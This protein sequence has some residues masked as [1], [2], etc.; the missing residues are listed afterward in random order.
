[1]HDWTATAIGTVG[2][3]LLL[4]AFLLNLA[5]K[6]RAD[7]HSYLLMNLAGATLAG[8]SSYLIRFWPF[9]VLEGVWALVAAVGLA[10]L[11]RGHEDGGRGREAA[12]EPAAEDEQVDDVVVTVDG[13]VVEL[14]ITDALDLH[15]FPPQRNRGRR[16][17]LPGGSDREGPPRGADH[18]RSR[19]RHAA[20]DRAQG[21]LARPARGRRSPT[22]QPT[23]EAGERRWWS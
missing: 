1:M 15:P 5:K 23:V 17:R 11:A 7:T 19:H 12:E 18:P 16:A 2:V 21:A 10:R 9:V 22:R 8:L 13:L 3:A 14:P 6:L 20:R 4:L